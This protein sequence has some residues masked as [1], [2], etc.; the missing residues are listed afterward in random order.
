MSGAKT[1]LNTLKTVLKS[2]GH[3]FPIPVMGYVG[4]AILPVSDAMHGDK[5]IKFY[6]SKTEAGGSHAAEGFAKATGHL[7]IMMSTSGPGVLNT[8]TSMQNARSDGTPLLVL[9]GQVSTKVLGTD[10]FQEAPV[11]EITKPI[12]KLSIMIKKSN[13]IET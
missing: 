12:T 3:P 7:G 5:D 9:A 11:L 13:T 10:A 8:V 4:G 2:R 1:L 6:P